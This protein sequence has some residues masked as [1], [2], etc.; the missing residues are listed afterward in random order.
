ML[1][2]RIIKREKSSKYDVFIDGEYAFTCDAET[3]F[4]LGIEEGK[5][6]TSEQYKY[7]VNYIEAKEAKNHAF[8]FLSRKML[9]EK[10]LADKLKLK[11]FSEEA[12]GEAVLKAKEYDYVNDENYAKFF[13]EEKMQS[14]YSRRRIYYELL[15]R[16]VEKEIIE[17]VLESIYPHEKEVEVIRQIVE[18]KKNSHREIQ[19]LKKYLYTNGFE[20]ENIEK[21][22]NLT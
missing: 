20:I 5:E 9:T 17:K 18:K 22:L 2:T 7:Y 19:K 12:I 13:V 8:K 4:M 10:Q 3:F 15:K 14:L 1:I 6:I 11:G 21:A 16:G